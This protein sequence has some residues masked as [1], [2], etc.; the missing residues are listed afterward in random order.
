MKCSGSV[1][2]AG[3]WCMAHTFKTTVE[4]LGKNMPSTSLSGEGGTLFSAS[5]GSRGGGF[6][7]VRSGKG[8]RGD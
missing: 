7:L 5:Q 2:V 1:H 8:G 3:S 6:S 4:P